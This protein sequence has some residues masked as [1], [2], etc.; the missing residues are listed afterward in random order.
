MVMSSRMTAIASGPRPY[1]VAQVRHTRPVHGTEQFELDVVGW[2]AVEKR[3][4]PPDQDRD[5]VNLQL[6][7]DTGGQCQPGSAGS[8]DQ[9]VPVAGRGLGPVHRGRDVADI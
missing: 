1:A 8:M 3:F 5:Q 4:T 7:Q 9:Y 6:V 2:H